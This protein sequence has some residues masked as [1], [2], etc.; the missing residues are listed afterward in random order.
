MGAILTN[1]ARAVS[2]VFPDCV[3]LGQA[4]AFNMFLAFFPLLLLALGLLGGTALFADAL[5]EIP[6]RL[7]MILP[8]GSSR[9]VA[10]YF[11]RRTV[12]PWTWF[13]LGL[14]GTL[15]AGTQVMV[16]FME[17]F[18]IIEGDL[19]RP[20]YWR[21]QMRALGLLCLTIVPMLAVVFLTVF[22]KQWRSLLRIGSARLTHELATA[23]YAAAVFILAMGVL[24]ALYRIGR[25]GH[26]GLRE[27]LPG[28]VVSTVLWWAADIA[29][30]AYVRR[31]PYDV[32]YRGLASAIG[33]LVWMFLTAIIVLLGAAYNA[34]AREASSRHPRVTLLTS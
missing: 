20:G 31:M 34:E 16:G 1:L 15:L 25:P 14:A 33:L 12:H 21:R 18:R 7:M 9:V 4:I 22:G 8:P 32:V 30:G 3:T 5:R 27:L 24:V 29:F 19:L 6:N 2:R 26:P 28:A 17:G 23:C 13:S 10:E 11:V